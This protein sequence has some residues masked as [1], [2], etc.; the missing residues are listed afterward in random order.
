MPFGTYTPA[1][2][3]TGRAGVSAIAV[4]AGTIA[5]SSGSARAAPAPRRNVRRG[6]AFLVITMWR[7]PVSSLARGGC[8]GDR[9]LAATGPP[10]L[11]RR[12]V[13]DPGHDRGPSIIRG[14]SI[15]DDRAND[16]HIRVLEAASERVGE[17][18]LR[19]RF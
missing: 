7:S 2:R 16:R 4:A 18:L 10:H 5:S 12:A 17:Q 19:E 13:H 8:R 1:K 3:R 15:A 11:E 6:N 9:H 14:T